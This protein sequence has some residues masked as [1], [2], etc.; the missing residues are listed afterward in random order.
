MNQNLKQ[1]N[2]HKAIKKTTTNISKSVGPIV[3][4]IDSTTLNDNLVKRFQGFLNSI[5]CEFEDVI[6]VTIFSP[7]DA[8]LLGIVD[9]D[10]KKRT[11]KRL[12]QETQK[13]WTEYAIDSK[14]TDFLISE[15]NSKRDRVLTLIQFAQRKKAKIIVV[16]SGAK[17]RNNLTGIG[18]FSE[19]LISLSP[20]PVLVL[21]ESVQV[22]QQSLAKILFPTDFSEAS[23]VTFRKV[24]QFAKNRHAEVVL[25]HFLNLEQGPLAYG[26]P[27]GYEI[28][29]LDEYW[30]VQEKL[31]E[32][33][34]EKWKNLALKLGVKSQFIC[35]RKIGKLSNRIVEIAQDNQIDMIA[36]AIKRGPW[37]QVL[38]GRNIR[39]LFAH[40]ICP[41]LTIHA[42]LKKE[43]FHS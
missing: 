36:V 31:Q 33:E 15:S 28:K 6:P 20:I 32:A 8:G 37:S 11:M 27:W 12:E 35:D 41:V 23:K 34:G 21:G 4:A 5:E 14:K 43:K 9:K 17:S 7:F 40:S 42:N 16:G 3:W 24:L 10:L 18:S 2:G 25:Y 29:W 19:A 30:S 22:T 13:Q 38:L 39:E 26:I 1:N